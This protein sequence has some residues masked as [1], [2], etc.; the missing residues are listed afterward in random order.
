MAAKD[1]IAG[2]KTYRKLATVR[3]FH[4]AFREIGKLRQTPNP[5]YFRI[6]KMP[7]IADRVVVHAPSFNDHDLPAVATIEVALG[8]GGHRLLD[9]HQAARLLEATSIRMA[10]KDARTETYRILATFRVFHQAIR[11]IER[12]PCGQI[13]R[14]R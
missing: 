4:Q 5:T 12:F 14:P 11:D 8:F 3:V 1:G 13:T 6:W 10:T 2:T 7:Q 9:R